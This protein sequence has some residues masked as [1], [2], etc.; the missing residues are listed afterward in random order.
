MIKGGRTLMSVYICALGLLTGS[1]PAARTANM[2]G[3]RKTFIVFEEV[4]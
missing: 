1:S 4:T 3:N 2:T